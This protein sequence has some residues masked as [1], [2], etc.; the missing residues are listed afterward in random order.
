MS[1]PDGL[2]YNLSEIGFYDSTRANSFYTTPGAG[3][4][5]DY[6]GAVINSGF[7]I[8]A[9]EEK[10]ER[11]RIMKLFLETEDIDTLPESDYKI[12]SNALKEFYR[13]TVVV[14]KVIKPAPPIVTPQTPST[15][16]SAPAGPAG[17]SAR[18][19][20]T[21]QKRSV[22]PVPPHTP[23]VKQPET[24]TLSSTRETALD[25]LILSI[26]TSEETTSESAKHAKSVS[27]LSQ[28]YQGGN[29]F[30]RYIVVSN[31]D[32]E[33]RH[34]F[35]Y[36]QDTPSI[37]KGFRYKVSLFNFDMLTFDIT[38]H[39]FAPVPT[40]ALNPNIALDPLT[41]INPAIRSD[42]RNYFRWAVKKLDRS[43]IESS[44]DYRNSKLTSIHSSDIFA[45]YF[46]L[47]I[48]DAVAVNCINP[49]KSTDSRGTLVSP[50]S[51]VVS[52]VIPHARGT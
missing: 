5:R 49:I 24:A 16:K 3:V 44:E 36:L 4:V 26:W 9:P 45:E 20:G 25:I 39:I 11:E 34:F 19:M 42:P 23:I 40:Y 6:N 46:G 21:E 43:L 22:T 7:I 10:K 41:A 17:V 12:Y 27:E 33:K 51:L 47:H 48:D 8:E 52:K 1:D 28:R 37:T 29:N 31:K 14:S 38:K 13:T 35:K 30:F 15:P 50:V 18:Q 32:E 2:A